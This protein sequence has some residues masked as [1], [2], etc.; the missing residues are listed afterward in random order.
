MAEDGRSLYMNLGN[1]PVRPGEIRVKAVLF[2][3]QDPA[4]NR[5]QDLEGGFSI[6]YTV[7]EMLA[8]GNGDQRLGVERIYHAIVDDGRSLE[9]RAMDPRRPLQDVLDLLMPKP[10]SESRPN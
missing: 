10:P 2:D 9:E 4:F 1:S 5:P 8:L 3:D 7:E 6:R